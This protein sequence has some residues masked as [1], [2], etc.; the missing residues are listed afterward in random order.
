M[1][2]KFILICRVEDHVSPLLKAITD[3]HFVRPDE[4]PPL[5]PNP[6][7]IESGVGHGDPFI[8]M[9]PSRELIAWMHTVLMLGEHFLSETEGAQASSLLPPQ[10][11]AC[12][13]AVA[14]CPR[15]GCPRG[16]NK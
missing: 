10:D 8:C 14:Y 6:V 13:G 5:P 12:H 11:C 16:L 9:R 7:S 15:A 2:T 4:L 3:A 1:A